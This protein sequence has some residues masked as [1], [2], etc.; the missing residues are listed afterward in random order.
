[1]RTIGLFIS[2]PD[3]AK[4][5][6]SSMELVH[7]GF[8]L[9]ENGNYW[10]KEDDALFDAVLDELAARKEGYLRGCILESL[11]ETLG[12]AFDGVP[13]EAWRG[14]RMSKYLG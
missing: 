2:T 3:D 12:I 14:T 9:A 11:Q 4:N 6:N 8:A 10:D 13:A 7:D 1:M 5:A